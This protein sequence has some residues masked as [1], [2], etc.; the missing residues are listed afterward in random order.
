ML[1]FLGH[2]EA[3]DAIVRAHRARASPTRI[4]RGRPTSAEGDDG[5]LGKAIAAAI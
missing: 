3:G 1:D 2:K 4:R 5:D